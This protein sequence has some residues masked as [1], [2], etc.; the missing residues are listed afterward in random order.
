MNLFLCWLHAFQHSNISSL[1][2]ILLFLTFLGNKTTSLSQ[3]IDPC[4]QLAA[5]SSC[6]FSFHISQFYCSIACSSQNLSLKN[7]W[8]LF[9]I[10]MLKFGDGFSPFQTS[11]NSKTDFVHSRKLLKYQDHNFYCKF[12]KTLV[13]NFR[14]QD[15]LCFRSI[16]P[17]SSL[18]NA[19]GTASAGKLL[20]PKYALKPALTL[21]NSYTSK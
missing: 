10:S 18:T 4:L 6:S 8:L 11:W 7:S 15:S 21:V 1:F 17:W 13:F 9:T 14:L 2:Y 3:H 19:A 20:T 5:R 12:E 16:P